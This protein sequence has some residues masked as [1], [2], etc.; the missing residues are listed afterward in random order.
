LTLTSG[1]FLEDL[2]KEDIQNFIDS[3]RERA[4]IKSLFYIQDFLAK[5]VQ[6]A[7]KN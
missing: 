2:T 7:Q 1:E 4:K 6:E 5:K 3:I